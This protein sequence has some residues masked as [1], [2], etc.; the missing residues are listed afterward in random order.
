M[1]LRIRSAGIAAVRLRASRVFDN[2]LV[3]YSNQGENRWV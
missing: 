3:Y 1:R 2:N